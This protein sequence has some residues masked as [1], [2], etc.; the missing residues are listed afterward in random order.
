MNEV[1]FPHILFC[2]LCKLC[3]TFNGG[4]LTL[5]GDRNN[6]VIATESSL[7][8]STLFSTLGVL[9]AQKFLVS[10]LFK[11]KCTEVISHAEFEYGGFVGL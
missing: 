7:G 8:Q 6:V 4:L 1:V 5:S 2:E 3:L 9:N 10:D 11:N